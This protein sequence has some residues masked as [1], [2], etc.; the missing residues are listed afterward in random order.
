MS[1][2]EFPELMSCEELRVQH[3]AADR[4]RKTAR[5]CSGACATIKTLLGAVCML[6]LLNLAG[7]FL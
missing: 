7:S 6:S 4:A 3:A 5:L 1:I 2:V